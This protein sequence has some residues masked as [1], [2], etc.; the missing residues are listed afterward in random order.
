MKFSFG[1]F[2]YEETWTGNLRVLGFAENAFTS[3]VH[4][5][6]FVNGKR[7][8]HIGEHAFRNLAIVEVQLP[9]TLDRICESAFENCDVLKKVS[10]D[11]LDLGI[12]SNAFAGCISLEQFYSMGVVEL[13]GPNVFSFCTSMN[14]FQTTFINSIPKESFNGCLN[15]KNFVFSGIT[16]V[17]SSAFM[18]CVLDKVLI[19]KDF[20]Y[21]DDFLEH[22]KTAI[23]FCNSNSKFVDL[24]YSGYHI[25]IHLYGGSI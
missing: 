7:V 24:A 19:E 9:I 14:E 25:S 23:I 6:D 11:S 21:C 15:L 5:P 3:K 12:E 10:C 17:R 22:I 13:L 1:Q 2:V 20:K 4:I 16:S 8:T 18:N